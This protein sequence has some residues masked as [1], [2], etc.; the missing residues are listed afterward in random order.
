MRNVRLR[1]DRRYGAAGLVLGAL[2][3]CATGCANLAAIREFAGVSAESAAYTRLV[4]EYVES[5]TRQKRY[6]P[7]SEHPRLD[8]MASERTAQK[9]ALLL[10]H[11]LLSEYMEALGQLAADEAVVYDEE[12]NALGR[13][14]TEAKF[15]D[16]GEADAF[17]AVTRVLLKAVAD[18]WRRRQLSQL[19]EGAN[20]PFQTVATSLR[21]IVIQGFGGDAQIERIAIDKFYGS[22]IA[23]SRDKAGITALREWQEVRI[24]GVSARDRA[25]AAY[26]EVLDRVAR[27]HQR[28]YD[29]RNDL[30]A[31]ALVADIKGYSRDLRRAFNRVRDEL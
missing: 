17:S 2:L 8:R 24:A 21:T 13:A 23:E 19:I 16:A 28:L 20:A 3:L 22:V 6:Q 10:R 26:G 30:S 4:G 31:K 27:G 1:G 25:I 11:R 7:A 15:L 14:A 5:P 12:V 18:G 9:E 29:G